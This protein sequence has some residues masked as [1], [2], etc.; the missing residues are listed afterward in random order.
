M[1]E[2]GLVYNFVELIEQGIKW[3]FENENFTQINVLFL[4]L[5]QNIN[6]HINTKHNLVE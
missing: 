5:F 3:F 1:L 4:F 2:K 6:S